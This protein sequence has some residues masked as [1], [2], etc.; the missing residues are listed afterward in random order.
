[1]KKYLNLKNSF[2]LLAGIALVVMLLGSLNAG[3]SGDEPTHYRDSIDITDYYAS[4]GKDTTAYRHSNYGAT[5][6]NIAYGIARVT[7]F[8]DSKLAIMNIRHL[9]GTFVGWLGILFAALAAWRLSNKKWLPAI[10]TLA[11]F[12]FSPRFIGHSFNNLK[13]PTM[14]SFFMMAIYGMIAFLQDF[15]KVRWK[16]ILLLIL[17]MGFAIAVRPVG[18]LLFAYMGM[19]GL[20]HF[21]LIQNGSIFSKKTG[22]KPVNYHKKN[23]NRFFLYGIIVFIGAYVF[24]VIQWPFLIKS[25][26]DNMFNSA[27]T[28]ASFPV[29]LTQLFEGQFYQSADIPKYYLEKWMLMTIPAVVLLGFVIRLATG[30]KRDDRFWTFML[31]FCV[32][33]PLFL[34][35]FRGTN[36]YGGW[37]H[38]I[39]TY[40]PMVVLAGMGF[41]SLIEKARKPIV[42]YVLTALPFVLLIHPAIFTFKNHPYEYLYFNELSGGIKKAYGKYE[43]DYYFHAMRECDEWVLKNAERFSNKKT[44]VA[45]W[46]MAIDEILFSK[47]TVNFRQ[48]FSRYYDRGE[49]DWDY[50]IF[51]VSGRGITPALMKNKK[52]FPPAGTVHT[53][54][55][56]DIPIGF[57][58]KRLDKNDYYGFNAMNQ[59][60]TDSAIACYKK[61]LQADPYNESALEHL[62]DIYLRI[63]QN[64]SAFEIASFWAQNV[65]DNTSALSLLANIYLQKRDVNSATTVATKMKKMFPREMQGYWLS[66]YAYLSAGQA[67][68]ALNDLKKVIE[69]RPDFKQAY[70]LM[71]QIYQ[72]SGDN[73]TAQQLLQYA[74][75]L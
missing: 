25:P 69:I 13:D 42:K 57:V 30:W 3:I 65:P 1:M 18:L 59:G 56:N 63:G 27:G 70:Q 20:L 45:S 39:F 29:V 34:I 49:R 48:T 8:T 41:Y 7:G 21:F 43:L 71:A 2:W 74:A 11:L 54:K 67:Q 44:L 40:P 50:A 52:A 9:C 26:I 55:V 31:L 38:A 5:V 22:K 33:F 4:F 37:R 14:A 6:D 10:I 35:G 16:T 64:D 19:F 23:F 66:A 46:G 32:I 12:V 15:P 24:A 60:L 73:Q 47:D 28:V 17:S 36:V 61:A 68:Y 75:Q 58:L 53:V 62:A 51:P 72:Q